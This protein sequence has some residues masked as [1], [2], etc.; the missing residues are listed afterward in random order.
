[1]SVDNGTPTGLSSTAVR[2][3]PCL[4]PR[5]KSTWSAEVARPLLAQMNRRPKTRPA[6]IDPSHGEE[7][8][9]QIVQALLLEWTL[10][11]EVQ[12][13][14]NFIDFVTS[15][16]GPLGMELSLIHI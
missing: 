6:L 15:S 9:R 1:M 12:R 2:W 7:L 8:Q 5:R 3:P 11:V 13:G 16:P 10:E 4:L 14:R